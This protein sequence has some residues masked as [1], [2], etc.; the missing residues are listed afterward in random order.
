MVCFDSA[1]YIEDAVVAVVVVVA[2]AVGPS[3]G[4]V[5]PFV[6]STDELIFFAILAADVV[7]VVYAEMAEFSGIIVSGIDELLAGSKLD[8]NAVVESSRTVME[9]REVIM[10]YLAVTVSSTT[11]VK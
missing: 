6:E 5:V 1:G 3:I 9:G 7:A 2:A 11:A 4:I 10:S 8:N